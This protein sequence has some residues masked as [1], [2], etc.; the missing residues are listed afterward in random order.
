[1]INP[2]VKY[3]GLEFFGMFENASGKARAESDTRTVNQYGAELLYRFGKNESIYFGGRYNLVTGETNAD[4][5]IDIARFNI[6]AGW[7][8]TKNVLAKLEYVNQQYDGFNS[9]S[10]FHDAEFKGMMLEAV[11]SF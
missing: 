5:D 9:G 10:F 8:L 2:F 4:E 11:I 7:F 6:G 3:Q 1:M